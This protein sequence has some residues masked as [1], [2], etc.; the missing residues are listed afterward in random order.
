M[1]IF[2]DRI[3]YWGSNRSRLVSDLRRHEKGRWYLFPSGVEE[4]FLP[5][6]FFSSFDCRRRVMHDLVDC[7]GVDPRD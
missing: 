6:H 7:L 4:T 1:E 2:G 3:L 5:K